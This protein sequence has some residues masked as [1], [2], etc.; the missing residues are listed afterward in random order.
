MHA[1][2][3]LNPDLRVLEARVFPVTLATYIVRELS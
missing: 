2:E 3:D 1:A